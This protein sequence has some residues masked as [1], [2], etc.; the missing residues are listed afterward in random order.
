MAILNLLDGVMIVIRRDRNIAAVYDFQTGLEGI[1]FQRNIVSSIKGQAARAC[2]DT[3]R[4]EASP[5]AVRCS[6]I[7]GNNRQLGPTL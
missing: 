2:T 1:D 6:S 5:W 3:G 7:L 4:T